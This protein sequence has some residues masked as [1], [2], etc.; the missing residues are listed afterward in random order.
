MT[1][2]VIDNVADASQRYRNMYGFHRN[3]YLKVLELTGR[4]SA[5]MAI[6]KKISA[7]ETEQVPLAELNMSKF[8][9][10]FAF[11]PTTELGMCISKS[12]R[13]ESRQGICANTITLDTMTQNSTVRTF[14][15][16]TE[17]SR[18]NL[19]KH[20]FFID[21]LQGKFDFDRERMA[22]RAEKSAEENLPRTHYPLSQKFSLIRSTEIPDTVLVSYL[23]E[24]IVGKWDNN[25]VIL[26]RQHTALAD[27]LTRLKIGVK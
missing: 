5:I 6:V 3:E 9:F 15:A 4:D 8:H 27:Q 11:N 18:E 24:F 16:R 12:P 2:L 10:G 7:T 25:K 1:N 19:I 14:D 26:G 22:Y 21:M 23:G 20:T 13:R 17:T